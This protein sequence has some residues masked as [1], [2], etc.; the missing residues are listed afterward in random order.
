MSD[1]VLLFE[2]GVWVIELKKASTAVSLKQI[3]DK[4]YAEKYASSLYLA[5]I[6]IEIDIAQ[7]SLKACEVDCGDEQTHFF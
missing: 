6:G 1:L 4:G 7:K 5:L 3:K 2:G